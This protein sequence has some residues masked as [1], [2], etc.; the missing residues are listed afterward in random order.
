MHNICDWP[1]NIAVEVIPTVSAPV[2]SYGRKKRSSGARF[3]PFRSTVSNDGSYSQIPTVSF[4]DN[5]RMLSNIA[6]AVA[7]LR[8]T[9]EGYGSATPIT[10]FKNMNTIRTV[11]GN[12]GSA[13]TAASLLTVPS[14]RQNV[15]T[16]T[17][18]TFHTT[19][20][21][22]T[23]SNLVSIPKTLP[24]SGYGG[25]T[26]SFVSTPYSTQVI[27]SAPV[28]YQSTNVAQAIFE[29]EVNAFECGSGKLC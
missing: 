2:S 3:V 7:T 19:T 20:S 29:E 6:P 18:P 17:V 27:Q 9:N 23:V 14:S 28:D 11:G 13:P 5:S 4:A 21:H 1:S 25:F 26:K 15:L 16:R 12:Y 24:S 22:R 8:T 10:E